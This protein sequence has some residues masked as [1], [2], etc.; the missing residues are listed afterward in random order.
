MID[1]L[2]LIERKIDDAAR[3]LNP[4]VIGGDVDVAKRAHDAL[5]ALA[6]AQLNVGL[7]QMEHDSKGAAS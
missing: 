3:H 1:R 4:L 5:N 7:L 6:A 2:A